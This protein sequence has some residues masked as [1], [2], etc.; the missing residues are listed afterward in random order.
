MR[1]HEARGNEVV[2]P[3]VEP[4]LPAEE[5]LM[6]D[7]YEKTEVQ[8]A[9]DSALFYNAEQCEEAEQVVGDSCEISD[10]YVSAESR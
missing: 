6:M 8:Q 2:Q 1:L 5:E 4:Q 7:K 3:L 9:K 10:E